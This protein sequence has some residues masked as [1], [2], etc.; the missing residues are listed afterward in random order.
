MNMKYTIAAVA[1]AFVFIITGCYMYGPEIQSWPEGYRLGTGGTWIV[2]TV[3]MI[4]FY[5]VED[6]DDDKTS[7]VEPYC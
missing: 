1:L 5:V 3:I 2:C 4:V 7:S 6:D